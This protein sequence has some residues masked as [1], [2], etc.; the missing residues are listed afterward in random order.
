MI[1]PRAVLTMNTPVFILENAAGPMRWRVSGVR[2]QFTEMTSEV[3]NRLSMET[4]IAPFS[5]VAL[6]KLKVAAEEDGG[7]T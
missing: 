4:Y 5:S 7:L 1:E 6:V 3:A 2:G